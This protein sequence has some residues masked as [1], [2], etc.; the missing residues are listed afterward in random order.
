MSG[1]SS[2]LLDPFIIDMLFD[3]GKSILDVGCGKGKW[4]YLVRTSCKPCNLIIGVDIDREHLEYVKKHK[5]YD[6]IL[7]D[8][9]RLPLKSATFDIVL[10]IDVIELLDRKGAYY[11]I[12]ECERVAREKIVIA[13]P[14]RSR[15]NIHTKWTAKDLKKWGFIVR[16]V[17]FS[18]LGAP[19]SH[20]L[21]FGLA[22][23]GYLLPDLSYVL[24]AWK[25][26]KI[27]K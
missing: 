11:L 23:L 2:V 25:R 9:R 22:V 16:G 8:A 24:L 26:L 4:G 6:I 20:R 21:I 5:I 17:G 7:C 15:L 10:A 3:E 19:V 14:N 13:T 1:G 27:S 12:A 18:P